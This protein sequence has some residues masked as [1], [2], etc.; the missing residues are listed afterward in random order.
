MEAPVPY[1]VRSRPGGRATASWKPA[2][3]VPARNEEER[4]PHL[5]E[6]LGRQTW[7]QSEGALTVTVVLNNCSD[8]SAAVARSAAADWSHLQLDL[9]E[10]EYE[11]GAAHVGSARRLAMDRALASV[12]GSSA[13]AVIMTTDADAVPEPNWV[14]ANLKAHAEGADL[15]GGLIIGDPDEEALLGSGFRRRAALQAEYA[16][17]ADRLTALI[18]PLPHDPW[19]RHHD[20]TGA[21]LSVRGDVYEAVGGLPVLPF[22][23][24]LGLVTRARALGFRLRHDPS[25]RVCVSARL[26]GRAPGGMADTLKAW[27]DAAREGQ[28]QLVEAPVGVERR[29]LRRAALRGL[30]ADLRNGAADGLI[31]PELVAAARRSGLEGIALVELLAPDEPDA[32]ATVSVRSAIAQLEGMI[33]ERET[34]LAAA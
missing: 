7:C 33:R 18:D 26:E 15:V 4:L 2:I 17:L 1:A 31:D 8:R 24:D 12:R 6:A 19:P 5:L 13:Q 14:T 32:P 30:N 9:I 22:R 28:P 27:A 11:P 10:V 23:E 25:V 29:A 16:E 3:A 34:T 21:S 20:H